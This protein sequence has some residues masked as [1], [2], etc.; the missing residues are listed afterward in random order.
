MT[1]SKSIG[2]SISKSITKK[3]IIAKMKT[4][5]DLTTA[6]AT[7]LCEGII[8]ELSGT[9]IN[10]EPVKCVNFGTFNVKE[11]P[12]RIGVNPQTGEKIK[13]NRSAGTYF[14][15]SS[16]ISGELNKTEELW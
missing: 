9:L 2:K 6:Q 1:I 12:E 10:G 3:D 8:N 11:R 7:Q 13:I 14:H 5:L 4:E 15:A 16:S